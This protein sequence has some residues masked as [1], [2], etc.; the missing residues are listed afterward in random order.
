VIG[1][2]LNP[3]ML[4]VARR[5]GGDIEYAEGDGQDLPFGDGEFDVAICQFGVMFYPDPARGFAELARVSRRGAVAVWDE[6][7]AGLIEAARDR[8]AAF[9]TAD[10]CVFGM[11]AKVATW[12]HDG[13]S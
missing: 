6:R 7:L 12:T 3:A 13:F 1:I 10:D 5:H 11:T 8:L 4:A 9:A 2:D